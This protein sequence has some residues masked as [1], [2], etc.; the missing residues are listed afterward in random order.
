M[1]GTATSLVTEGSIALKFKNCTI[2]LSRE[3]HIHVMLD[4]L[5]FGLIKPNCKNQH[6]EKYSVRVALLSSLTDGATRWLEKSDMRRTGLFV[7]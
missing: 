3:R 6:Q 2:N 5:N 4:S 1:S 7:S